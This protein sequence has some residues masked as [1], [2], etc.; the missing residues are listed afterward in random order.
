MA[1]VVPQ[2]DRPTVIRAG[3]TVDLVE[4]LTKRI[5]EDEAQA[6]AAQKRNGGE[7]QVEDLDR[8]DLTYAYFGARIRGTVGPGHP[9]NGYPDE[10][11]LWDDETALGMWPETGAHVARWDP[12]RVLAECEAK[13]AIVQQY[14]ALRA[15]EDYYHEDM[16]A[17]ALALVLRHLAA[18]YADHPDYPLERTPQVWAATPTRA[19]L[20]AATD[21]TDLTGSGG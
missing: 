15:N 1:A 18:I 2:M 19:E 6:E 11:N 7:W 4:F 8:D 20:D 14:H 9:H 3:V 12:A 21:L 10:L 5:E 13:R 17:G 16:G